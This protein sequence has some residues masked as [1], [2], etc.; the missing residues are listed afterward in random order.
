MT[1]RSYRLTPRRYLG[2]GAAA[3]LAVAVSP[4]AGAQDVVPSQVPMVLPSALPPN[5]VLTLDDSPGMANAFPL[6]PDFVL[7]ASG[8][9]VATNGA[10]AP[11][12]AR[13]FKSSTFNPLYYNPSVSYIVPNGA[14][15]SATSFSAALVNGYY[16]GNQS[17]W[18]IDLSRNYRPT[19][20]YAPAFNNSGNTQVFA[21]HAAADLAAIGG[22]S[23]TSG[24]RAY[25]Y[26]YDVS[27]AGCSR[28]VSDDNCYRLQQVS[29]SEE[30]N[31]ANWYSYYRTRHLAMVSSAWRVM[32]DQE[33]V[34]TRVGWQALNSCNSFAAGSTCP[35]NTASPSNN[36]PDRSNLIQEFTSAR[37]EDLRGWLRAVRP[38]AP[39]TSPISPA[40]PLRDALRRAGNYYSSSGSTNNP[41]LEY[42]QVTFDA[43]TN[44]EYACRPNFHILMAGSA[45]DDTGTS[46][47]SGAN[48]GDKD[49]TNQTFPIST[50]N[51]TA[52]YSPAAPYR[53]GS[54]AN[55]N[56]LAD[57]AFH[58][59]VTDLRSNLANDKLL[60]YYVDRAGSLSQQD[61][62]PKNDPARWQHMV[63]L[64]VGVGLGRALNYTGP[65]TTPPA[66]WGDT[67]QASGK[68][69][70]LWHAAVN[71]RGGFFG[72]D[73]PGQIVDA[74]T[75]SL[76]RVA[77]LNR[78]ANGT[79]N[80]SVGAALATNS[81]RLTTES[82]LYQ[83]QFRVDDW[84]GRLARI[85]VDSSGALQCSLEGTPA[86]VEASSLIPA[87]DAR[88]IV[89]SSGALRSGVAFNQAG[90]AALGVWTALGADDT[91]R[92]A[93]LNYLRGDQS[94]EGTSSGQFRVRSAR[95][96]DIVN[97]DIVFAGKENFGYQNLSPDNFDT[98]NLN[99]NSYADFVATK[100][101]RQ[102][103][104]YVAANDGM[105]HGFDAERLVERFAYVPR[106]LLLERVSVGDPRPALAQ[107]SD[108][109]YNGAHRFFADGSPWVGDACL[110]SPAS[111]CT[112]T[113][114][115][116]VLVGTTGAGGKGVF[117]IDVT[118]P[119]S[120]ST[121]N[122]LWD[123][124]GEGDPD[125][126]YV[127]GQP[128]IGRLRDSNYYA[129]FGNGYSSERGCP[130]LYL[131]NLTTGSIRRLSAT[132]GNLGSGNGTSECSGA[133]TGLGRPSLFDADKDRVTDAIYVGDTLG[134][135]W[136][137][138]VSSTDPANWGV[139]TRSGNA[140]VPL[141]TARNKCGGVQSITGLIEIGAPPP[142][143]APTGAMLYFGTGRF[144]AQGDRADET[145]QT[146]YGIFDRNSST[147]ALNNPGT[148][149][150]GETPCTSPAVTDSNG[151]LSKR[152]GLQ[153]QIL[154][155]L[156][157][158]NRR[159]I[160]SNT[161]V[162]Y[163]S[164][165]KNLGWY[166]DL[167][168]AGERMVTAP[169]L[170]GGRVVFPT[171][172][173]TADACDGGGYSMIVAVDPFS[174]KKTVRNI[175]DYAN[176]GTITYDSFKMAVGVVK[177]VVAIDAGSRVYL[178]AGGSSSNVEV[179]QTRAVEQ[180]GGA[181]RGRVS[182]RE[183]VK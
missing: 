126:G 12:N 121:A 141:F 46:Y 50:V 164:N 172:V 56:S 88:N 140:A 153:E 53:D 183:I 125:L 58:Y 28:S 101:T 120:F 8:N 137:F 87:H 47:C 154:G 3:A 2:F 159:E 162:N 1:P 142:G 128:V 18:T 178:F 98:N 19:L 115:R 95:L 90:L 86:C 45:W 139:F 49:G 175:F 127:V 171:L 30:Q 138:D 80:F 60:P 122:V 40:A 55:S 130:V 152:E 181:V 108:Q 10:A 34:G 21:D 63:N 112:S 70:D 32:S 71:S 165:Q 35:T 134:R 79:V 37:R 29:A 69:F 6:G 111:N 177:N 131:V 158:N 143:Q 20:S 23:A 43:S 129:I 64:V 149:T 106:A 167:P 48:C 118:A 14:L 161:A 100:A 57:I 110:K 105:L 151:D 157:A 91:A 117:A 89:T 174:G 5:I 179:I 9:G 78:N 74:L 107:L 169:T 62:N 119:A 24:V 92:A 25:Y 83:A 136:K 103:M 93:V 173:P 17:G 59:W 51:G 52:S 7:L 13:R 96:G 148:A 133:R 81:T 42:P 85:P 155:T 38:A 132:E 26:I 31:F 99:T 160:T 144:L 116:T 72:A 166:I 146:F 39:N 16:T 124:A 113:D 41:Y 4:L 114:W 61:A 73:T 44:R 97:S 123:M 145:R 163:T 22:A 102:K 67:A 68:L 11:A 82:A 104:I 176:T 180:T 135:L 94:N 168:I 54:P 76:S 150:S 170:L 65:N 27:L 66:N 15:S 36:P 109:N 156:D 75:A 77:P 147:A 182:W 33:L 84:T